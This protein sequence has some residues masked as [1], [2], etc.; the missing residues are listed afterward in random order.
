[1]SVYD[2]DTEKHF[3][4]SVSRDFMSRVTVLPSDLRTP[5]HFLRVGIKHHCGAEADKGKTT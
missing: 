1:V 2:N 3:S 5:T 4:C